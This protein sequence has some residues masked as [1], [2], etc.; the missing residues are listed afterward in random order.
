MIPPEAQVLAA[1]FATDPV[2]TYLWPD[3]S[4]RERALPGFWASRLASR[5]AGG[6]VDVAR[7]EAG[8][9]VSVALWEPPGFVAPVAEPLL[10]IRA[11]GRAVPRAR[12]VG[13]V[14]ERSRPSGPHLYFAAL[15]TLPDYRGRGF[16]TRL[17]ADRLAQSEVPVFLVCNDR[18]NVRSCVKRG[19]QQQGS[20][21]IPHGP[22]V[23][24]MLFVGS[25]TAEH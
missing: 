11:L 17:V 4:R 20:L 21:S 22:V 19:F 7:D 9:V 25:A 14:M 24:P 6:I 1:A 10:L 18:E 16:G 2:M 23:Y 5:R 12:T 15:A 3:R 13:R 8:R